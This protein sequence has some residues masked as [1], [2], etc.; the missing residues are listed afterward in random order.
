MK[1]AISIPDETFERAERTATAM[2]M[3]RS[4]FFAH[5]AQHYLDELETRT[6]AARIDAAVALV[7]HDESSHAAVAS[8]R[9]LLAAGEDEW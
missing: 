1:T 8:G 9:R 3:S 7:G 5:A 6:L 4:E 2:G